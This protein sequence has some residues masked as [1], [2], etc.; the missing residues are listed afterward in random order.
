M[1]KEIRG[2]HPSHMEIWNPPVTGHGRVSFT[3]IYQKKRGSVLT[4]TGQT[5]GS[6]GITLKAPVRVPD[7]PSGF[8]IVRS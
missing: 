4:A 7:W 3:T 6:G 8:V 5:G 2:T 1:V